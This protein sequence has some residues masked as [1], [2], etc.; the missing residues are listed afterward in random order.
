MREP[1]SFCGIVGMK[2]TYGRVSRYGL[3]AMGSSLDCIGPIAKNVADAEIIYEA[4]AGQDALDD[5]MDESWDSG[6]D[7][8][9][10]HSYTTIS[11]SAPA[12]VYRAMID[13]ALGVRRIS[14]TDP[15]HS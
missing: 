15:N 5:C 13:A 14:D 11:P 4:I 2:P 8:E 12:Q 9:G 7:G 3:I 10:F 6:G 1:A